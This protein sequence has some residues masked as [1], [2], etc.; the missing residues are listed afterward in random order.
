[1]SEPFRTNFKH[2]LPSRFDQKKAAKLTAEALERA[3]FKQVDARDHR[4][5]RVCGKASDPEAIGILERGHRHHIVY[6]SAGG[7]T[8]SSN[9]VTLCAQHHSEEHQHRLRI[10]GSADEGLTFWK[11]EDGGEWF[12]W[13]SES[14]P[15]V[16][17]RD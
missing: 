9:L 10:D 2:E 16:F 7:S 6:R 12:V 3:V 13:R 15:G 1:M 14:A 4:R 17:Y 5:C 8:E 11:R